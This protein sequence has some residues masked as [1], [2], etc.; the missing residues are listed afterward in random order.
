VLDAGMPKRVVLGETAEFLALVRHESSGGLRAVLQVEESSV[1]PEDVRSR[2]FEMEFPLDAAGRLM[3][4]A[5]VLRVESPDFDPPSQEKRILVP[6]EGDS[7]PYRF[8]LK[9]QRVGQLMLMINVLIEDVHRTSASFRVTADQQQAAPAMGGFTLLSIPLFT[10]STAPRP[11]PVAAPKMSPPAASMPAGMPP[12]MSPEMPPQPAPR[13]SD[14]GEFT[15]MTSS[16]RGGTQTASERA[17]VSSRRYAPAML[18][19]VAAML[20]VAIVVALYV[21]IR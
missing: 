8:L 19:L 5:V 9:A 13:T 6:P 20:I 21:A 3:P 7:E 12:E 14:P 4:A 17:P 18:L 10:L 1:A 11:A 15:R 2:S 16:P